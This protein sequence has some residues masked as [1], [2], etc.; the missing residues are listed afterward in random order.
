MCINVNVKASNICI[1]S[2]AVHMMHILIINLTGFHNFIS[3][4]ALWTS[5]QHEKETLV[6]QMNDAERKMAMYTTAKA[7]SI[8]QA[9]EK[10]QRYM[11]RHCLTLIKQK[12]YS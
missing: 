5:F 2:C 1:H 8:Q 10:C 12:Y 4:A 7:I 3:C 11:V 9:E 6:E